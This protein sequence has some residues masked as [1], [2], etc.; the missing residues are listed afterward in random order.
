M[1][2]FM[3]F[4]YLR[5]Q[6]LLLVLCFIC[7]PL[8][9]LDPCGNHYSPCK[10]PKEYTDGKHRRAAKNQYHVAPPLKVFDDLAGMLIPPFAHAKR[11]AGSR[12]PVAAAAAP[13]AIVGG[14]HHT[15]P[16]FQGFSRAFGAILRENG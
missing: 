6:A 8:F 7:S 12:T 13:A 15:V 16:R 2:R 11:Y 3:T 1:L 5:A 9:K 14:G 10:C 4:K